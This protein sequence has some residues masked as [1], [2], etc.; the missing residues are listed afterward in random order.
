M[1]GHFLCSVKLECDFV[2]AM[3]YCRQLVLNLIF[4]SYTLLITG[5]LLIQ[6]NG[7]D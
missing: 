6:S 4:L 5:M 3:K 1:L 2:F 7:V